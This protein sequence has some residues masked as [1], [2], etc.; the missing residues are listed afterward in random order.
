[1]KIAV[2]IDTQNVYFSLKNTR[3]NAKLDY[4]KLMEHIAD[5]GEIVLAF[6]YGYQS[7]TEAVSFITML[8]AIGVTPRFSRN[9]NS[10]SV[11]LACDVMKSLYNHEIDTIVLV[12][13]DGALA[14]LIKHANHHNVKI[15]VMAATPSKEFEAAYDCIELP[16]SVLRR[17]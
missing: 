12:T 13:S 7:D 10:R 8:R 1:M 11:E 15:I 14:P 3:D 2:Y 9:S 17:D 6:G 4:P 16:N 5:L